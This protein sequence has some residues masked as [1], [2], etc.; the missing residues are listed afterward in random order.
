MPPTS[1]EV[2]F[3]PTQ[4][5]KK[6]KA[7]KAAAQA[8]WDARLCSKSEDMR[9][10]TLNKLDKKNTV[11][12]P[13]TKNCSAVTSENEGALTPFQ[14]ECADAANALIQQKP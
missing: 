4:G 14:K 5:A 10:D 11:R 3:R 8:E 12:K 2:P 9:W 13:R 1:G 7:D 6:Y